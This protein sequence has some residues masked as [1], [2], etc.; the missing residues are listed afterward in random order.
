MPRGCA[1]LRRMPSVAEREVVP[2]GAARP[3]CR[4]RAAV[5][6]RDVDRRECDG[7]GRLCEEFER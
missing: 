1:K 3:S 7:G 6:K 4:C 5:A 2:S